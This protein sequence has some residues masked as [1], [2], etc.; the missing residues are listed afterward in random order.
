[1]TTIYRAAW[2]RGVSVE[3]HISEAVLGR[4]YIDVGGVAE[5]LEE[6][7]SAVAPADQSGSPTNP[8]RAVC[9]WVM[10]L[11]PNAKNSTARRIP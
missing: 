3:D 5:S 6:A 7:A 1:M 4:A 11:T 9:A 10:S 8:H 2:Q